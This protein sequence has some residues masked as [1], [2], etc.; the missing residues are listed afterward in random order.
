LTDLDGYFLG[1]WVGGF[2]DSKMALAALNSQPTR[3][4]VPEKISANMG[5]K[6]MI[7][8]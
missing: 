7:L 2:Y 3:K 4:P 1:G 8:S 6:L 5:K